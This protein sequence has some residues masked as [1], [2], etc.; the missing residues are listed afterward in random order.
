MLDSENTEGHHKH[1]DKCPDN[2][3]VTAVTPQRGFQNSVAK[4]RRLKAGQFFLGAWSIKRSKVDFVWYPTVG[5]SF[6][7]PVEK[8]IPDSI[9]FS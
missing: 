9:L 8:Q 2:S 5:C 1:P 4:R 6:Q 3:L 7:D